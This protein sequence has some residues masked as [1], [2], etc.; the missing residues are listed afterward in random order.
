MRRMENDWL[1]IKQ[2]DH[3]ADSIR[4]ILREDRSVLSGR[5]VEDLEDGA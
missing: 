5:T 4:D 3:F 2:A 1:L